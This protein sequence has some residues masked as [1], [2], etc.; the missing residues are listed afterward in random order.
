MDEAI[1]GSIVDAPAAFTARR[2][3]AFQEVDAAGIVFYARF[4]DYFHDAY[5]GWLEDRGVPLDAA[6]RDGTWA[7]PLRHAEADYLRPLRFGEEIGVAVVVLAV[8]DTELT[9]GYRVTREEEPVCFGLTR[10]VSVDVATFR[11][12]PFPD[13]VR[14]ALEGGAAG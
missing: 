1:R 5:V 3:V 6:L 9:L 13:A 2:R 12:A 7:A 4:F 10:H 8:D 11:R 14:D